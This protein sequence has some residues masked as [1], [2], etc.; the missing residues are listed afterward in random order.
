MERFYSCRQ[1]L[2]E[3]IRIYERNV[4]HEKR[5]QF[6]QGWPSWPPFNCFG[7]PEWP[8]CP[9]GQEFTGR[10]VTKETILAHNFFLALRRK[11]N[12]RYNYTF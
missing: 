8:P 7:T 12:P 1:H 5:V 3:F 9:D 6:P 2:C 4:L 11:F 10:T